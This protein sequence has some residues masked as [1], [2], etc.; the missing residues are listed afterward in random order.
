MVATITTQSGFSFS[1]IFCK[2]FETAYYNKGIAYNYLGN[3]FEAQKNYF[4]AIN[5]NKSYHQAYNNLGSILIKNKQIDEA[6]NVLENAI[7]LKPDYIEALT[8]LGVAYLD[9]KKNQEDTTTRFQI[10]LVQ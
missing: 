3:L 4:E 9:L 2:I 1:T 6:I 7:N 5:I 10:L 8:N